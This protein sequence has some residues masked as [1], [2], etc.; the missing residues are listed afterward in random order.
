ML[1]SARVPI[2]TLTRTSRSRQ[3]GSEYCK[4]G[5]NDRYRQCG[6]SRQASSLQDTG[7][8]AQQGG[9]F[10]EIGRWQWHVD[11]RQALCDFPKLNSAA[12]PRQLQPERIK[13]SPALDHSKQNVSGTGVPSRVTSLF[14][15]GFL[16]QQ[17]RQLDVNSKISGNRR[18]FG[19]ES[20]KTMSIPVENGRCVT[21]DRIKNL[22]SG[23]D[24]IMFSIPSLTTCMNRSQANDKVRTRL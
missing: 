13:P 1:G 12:T 6:R 14:P 24:P 22:P 11:N 9:A 4:R 8:N 20:P 5:N 16:L 17:T 15:R 7:D 10:A 18:E 2:W 23:I 19:S 21:S 3:V